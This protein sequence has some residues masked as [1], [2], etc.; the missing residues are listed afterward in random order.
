[1]WMLG[2]CKEYGM[3][4]EQDIEGAKQLYEKSMFLKSLAGKLLYDIGISHDKD[5][6]GQYKMKTYF[7]L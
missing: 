5:I 1:M 2:L 4:T 6:R 7:R 3:G